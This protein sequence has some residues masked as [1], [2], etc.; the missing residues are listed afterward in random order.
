MTK[1]P[2]SFTDKRLFFINGVASRK[3]VI[4]YKIRLPEEIKMFRPF[5]PQAH[6]ITVRLPIENTVVLK[7]TIVENSKP[8]RTLLSLVNQPPSITPE[9]KAFI[10]RGNKAEAAILPVPPGK[11]P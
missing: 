11:A 5:N 7:R 10:I 4:F 8:M 6:Y 9:G 2:R 3:K 1:F